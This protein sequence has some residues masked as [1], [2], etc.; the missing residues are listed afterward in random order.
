MEHTKFATTRMQPHWAGKGGRGEG[1]DRLHKAPTDYTKPQKDQN[2][3]DKS[4]NKYKLNTKYQISNITNHIY[5][6]IALQ[7]Q[8]YQ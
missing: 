3:F 6:Y 8:Y 5:I 4:S 2:T 7:K 1:P